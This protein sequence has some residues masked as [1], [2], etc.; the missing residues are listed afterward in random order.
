MLEAAAGILTAGLAERAAEIELLRQEFPNLA[1]LP[2]DRNSYD[3]RPVIPQ[4]R[5]LI[6]QAL[7][8]RLSPAR[9]LLDLARE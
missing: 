1:A 5:V 9:Y 3:T 4:P 8:R 7:R 2:L 6:V